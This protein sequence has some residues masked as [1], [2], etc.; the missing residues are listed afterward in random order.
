MHGQP[1]ESEGQL[2]SGVKVKYLLD[3]IDA[4]INEQ[5]GIVC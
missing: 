3:V 5:S 4:F 2:E 1:K